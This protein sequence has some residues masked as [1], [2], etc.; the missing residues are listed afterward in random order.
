MQTK[1]QTLRADIQAFRAVAVLLVVV[2]HLWPTRLPGGYIGVDVF[3]VISGFLITSHL[4]RELAQR[5]KV[6]L[7]K[8]YAARIRRLIPAS[9]TVLM[10]TGLAVFFLLP[11]TTMQIELRQLVSSVFYL[12]NWQLAAEASDYLGSQN[13]A[14]AVRHFWSMSAEE[15]FYLF[16]P[17][18]LMLAA[19]FARRRGKTPLRAA[20]KAIGAVTL[21]SLLFS[22]WFTAVAPAAAYYITPTRVW[23][24]GAGAILAIFQTLRPSS[25]ESATSPVRQLFERL[26]LPVGAVILISSGFLLTAATPFPSFW[27]LLP[28][29]ASILLLIGGPT[30]KPGGW[31][32]R[33]MEFRPVQQVGNLSY[34]IYLW[35]WPLIVLVPR[36][37]PFDKF[38]IL[39]VGIIFASIALAYLTKRFIQDPIRYSP[40]VVALGMKKALTAL[41]VASLVIATPAVATGGGLATAAKNDIAGSVAVLRDQS[42]CLGVRALVF[43]FRCPINNGK[44]LY[45]SQQAMLTDTGIGYTCYVQ[46]PADDLKICNYG[47]VKKPKK[48]IAIVGD[49]H[50]AMMLALLNTEAKVRGWQLTTFVG[51]GCLWSTVA[52]DNLTDPCHDRI[53]KTSSNLL[54][55]HF[56]AVILVSRRSPEFTNGLLRNNFDAAP[57]QWAQVTKTG[58]K[59]IVVSDNPM[60]PLN[61][62]DC[63][64]AATDLVKAR[65]VCT[66]SQHDGYAPDDSAYRTA[67]SA[68]VKNLYR[69][70]TAKYFCVKHRCPMIIGDVVVYRDR[71]HITASYGYTLGPVIAASVQKI[72]TQQQ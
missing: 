68:G 18:L 42:N 19:L 20:L 47:E 26:S 53:A 6:S 39:R 24:F 63:V 2:F 57:M 65:S 44:T 25:E 16:W 4:A 14:T 69:L 38:G 32:S 61:Q 48:R 43:S 60:V 35:H 13:G 50:A 45:P 66:F 51:R 64:Q 36:L 54:G 58:T 8:F 3:F 1:P 34:G 41:L 10:V 31:L 71:D 5:G 40:K 62:V 11:P 72:L 21:L 49:S 12:Q 52:V 37:V 22:I 27:A 7:G 9:F 15:Q 28:V 33:A 30:S 67:M 55:S 59:L 29:A 46:Q 17:L 70:D 23:E 56:D